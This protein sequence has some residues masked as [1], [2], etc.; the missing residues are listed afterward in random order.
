MNKRQKKKKE[1]EKSI[2]EINRSLKII[3]Q[4]I[5]DIEIVE[6]RNCLATNKEFSSIKKAIVDQQEL[7]HA[8]AE[9]LAELQDYVLN[10]LTNKRPFWQFWK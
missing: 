8:L 1:I 5:L 6:S 2:A 9:A 3:N 4:E 10:D 7:T